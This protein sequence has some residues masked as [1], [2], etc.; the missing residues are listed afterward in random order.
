MIVLLIILFRHV[1]LIYNIQSVEIVWFY[2]LKTL[3]P[4]KMLNNINIDLFNFF[5]KIYNG[6]FVIKEK[7]FSKK[8]AFIL[9]LF[10]MRNLRLEP[11]FSNPAVM[12]QQHI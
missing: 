4:S 5:S 1:Y 11:N 9:F 6:F 2:V 7:K 12:T 10:S 8:I 3:V